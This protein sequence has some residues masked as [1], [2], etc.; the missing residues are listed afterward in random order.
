[1]IVFASQA[2]RRAP[3]ALARGGAE[4]RIIS[5][6]CPLRHVSTSMT[7]A[8]DCSRMDA[9]W[10]HG[11]SGSI[12]GRWV[13]SSNNSACIQ[14][15]PSPSFVTTLTRT[16]PSRPSTAATCQPGRGHRPPD[17]PTAPTDPRVRFMGGLR[18]T[19]NG[20]LPARSLSLARSRIDLRLGWL[21][22]S[23]QLLR[24]YL[25]TCVVCVV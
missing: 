22:D 17:T 9:P 25:A 2:V 12:P 24:C 3:Q 21:P 1:M 11:A 10:D 15:T 7:V 16:C 23:R 8:Y 19:R 5:I 13:P 18:R 6:E 4:P 14:S 20:A